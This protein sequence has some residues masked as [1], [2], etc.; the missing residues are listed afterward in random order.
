MSVEAFSSV[1]Y[2]SFLAGISIHSRV[3]DAMA[4]ILVD[5]DVSEF[6]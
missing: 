6:A 5:P 4:G 1:F 3:P 2:G